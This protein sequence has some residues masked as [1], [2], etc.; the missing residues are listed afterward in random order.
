MRS[1]PDHPVCCLNNPESLKNPKPL[2]HHH[3]QS[4]HVLESFVWSCCRFPRRKYCVFEVLGWELRNPSW[5]LSCKAVIWCEAGKALPIFLCFLIFVS[6]S[7]LALESS[8]LFAPQAFCTLRT[9]C[10]LLAV[11][12]VIMCFMYLCITGTLSESS[13][14]FRVVLPDNLICVLFS[15]LFFSLHS[16]FSS[17]FGCF[18]KGNC[19]ISLWCTELG[20]RCADWLLMSAKGTVKDRE[21]QGQWP[22]Q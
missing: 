19:Q 20:W 17:P 3:R 11:P 7:Y 21:L 13:S 18:G 2:H 5:V 1:I 10:N 12:M 14:E 16:V 6:P 15:L 9:V 8:R 22:R 4:W